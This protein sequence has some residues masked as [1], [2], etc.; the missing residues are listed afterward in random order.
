MGMFNSIVCDY[1]L[2]NLPGFVKPGHKFQTK[3]IHPSI[4]DTY[5]IDATGRVS[6]DDFT[7]DVEFYTYDGDR[8]GRLTYAARFVAGQLVRIARTS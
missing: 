1:A 5:K 2:P 7:G 6:L 4:L 3:D 8:P